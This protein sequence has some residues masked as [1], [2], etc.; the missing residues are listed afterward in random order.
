MTLL[1]TPPFPEPMEMM[2][3]IGIRYVGVQSLVRGMHVQDL[4]QSLSTAGQT[5]AGSD[6]I[7]LLNQVGETVMMAPA[8]SSIAP[9]AKGRLTDGEATKRL[10][11]PPEGHLAGGDKCTIV[12]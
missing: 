11:K 6:G 7:P 1:P 5:P 3:G 4:C 9:L 8:R 10:C 12:Y 2:L